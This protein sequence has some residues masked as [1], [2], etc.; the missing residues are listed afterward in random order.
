MY[1][2]IHFDHDIKY[3]KYEKKSEKRRSKAWFFFFFQLSYAQAYSYTYQLNYPHILSLSHN[4]LYCDLIS[5][6]YVM[7]S[8]LPNLRLKKEKKVRSILNFLT[9]FFLIIY[10]NKVETC[11][12]C[13]KYGAKHIWWDLQPWKISSCILFF[14][15]FFPSI[16]C[17]FY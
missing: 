5:S 10:P 4:L 13:S 17:D 7:K 3:K 9:F 8:L 12:L 15:V 14:C 11:P 1:D 2:Y 6:V 16:L